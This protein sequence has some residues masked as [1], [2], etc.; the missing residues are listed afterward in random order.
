MDANVREVIFRIDL[1][2]RAIQSSDL[3]RALRE[4]LRAYVYLE[5]IGTQPSSPV[6]PHAILTQFNTVIETLQAAGLI[7]RGVV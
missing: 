5:A 3:P 7:K 4:L 1:S 2:H 6:V